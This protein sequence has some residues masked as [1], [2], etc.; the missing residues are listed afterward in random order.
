M[1]CK[2]FGICL[3]GVLLQNLVRPI[4]YYSKRF[5]NSTFLGGSSNINAGICPVP[6]RDDI[7][8]CLGKSFLGDWD[9]F[10]NKELS[11]VSSLTTTSPGLVRLA[12]VL[13]RDLG[14]I[15]GQCRSFTRGWSRI[16]PVSFIRDATNVS[17]ITERADRVL[18]DKN[19]RAVGVCFSPRGNITA[20]C[21]LRFAA[22]LSKRLAC[23]QGLALAIPKWLQKVEVY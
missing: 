21:G 18:F 6:D 10:I 2:I 12:R 3:L 15:G 5:A 9:D 4:K 7:A 16:H 22:E 20:K 8:A 11:K 13:K 19:N 14:M 23:S 17:V 1:F